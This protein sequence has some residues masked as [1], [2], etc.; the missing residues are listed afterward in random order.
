AQV[1]VPLPDNLTTW[2]L[3]AVAA[4]QDTLVGSA[5]TDVVTSKPLL[6]RPATP[7]FLV[8]GDQVLME[9]IVHNYTDQAAPTEVSL[10]A[11]GLSTDDGA[12]RQVRIPA[13]G[14]AK[15]GW[16]LT[17]ARGAEAAVLTFAAS[18]GGDADRV[19]LTLPVKRYASPET[20][21]NAG[22][23]RDAVQEIVEIPGY[24]DRERG[25]LTITAEPSLAA[26][27]AAGLDYLKEYPFE[28]TETTV[29]RFL[30]RLAAA[31]AITKLGLPDPTG[32]RDELPG[33]VARSL[34]RLYSFQNQ[35]GGWGWC[36]RDQS[37]PALTAYA[38]LGLSQARQDGYAVDEGVVQRAA[39]YLR[40]YL[41][42]P[43]D[44]EDP[45][46]AD[47]RAFV[48]Y[49]L[50]AAGQ[51]DL[52]R[53]TLLADQ[54]ETLG[55]RGKAWAAL[56]LATVANDRGHAGV[57]ALLSD[58][59]TAALVSNTG[60]H[61]EDARTDHRSMITNTSTTAI[62]LEA[63]VR[64]NSDHPLVD[65]GVRWLMAARQEGRWRSTY[66][67]SWSLLALTDFL[68]VRGET[69][70]N[71]AYLVMVNDRQVGTGRV[72]GARGLEPQRLVVAVRDLLLDEENRVNIA[73]NGSGGPL[74]YTMHLQYFPDAEY[75]ESVSE[76]L[77]IAREYSLAD[78][79][80]GRPVQEARAGDVIKATITLVAP[81]DLHFVTVEDPFPAGLEP[82]D[83]SLKTTSREFQ[84]KLEA[85]RRKGMEEARGEDRP[86]W[87][88]WGQAE[89]R[90]DRL[91][92]MARF[93]PKGVH[94]YTYFLQVTRP[95]EY[96]VLPIRAYEQYFPEVWGRSDGSTFTVQEE[97]R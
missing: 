66:E 54:R 18:A 30:P 20:T 79:E 31:R 43:S 71:Y 35:D 65:N 16:R 23:V 46:R 53:S 75:I 40:S 14:S 61:W 92:L 95:G 21:G 57:Q 90:D 64:L 47:T 91:A 7:R 4:T 41:D 63:L 78:D 81:Q 60:T 6:V 83:A 77:S 3:I 34:Q 80:D 58:L 49:V 94:E 89:L 9:A 73:R 11:Q 17:V 13:G 97:P 32:L 59:T 84:E 12:P 69:R 44:V 38:L 55:N 48:L 76:G 68:E 96:R 82:I 39:G 86:Y 52:G 5:T 28:C 70:G 33:L 24:V 67:T 72:E 15:V 42:R 25:E 50:A 93:L 88:Y 1:S 8:A 87:Y 2:R 85:E 51:G 10:E 26:G 36:A 74:Y 45:T 37:E 62:V 29:S 27:M 19:Q 56:A 22:V